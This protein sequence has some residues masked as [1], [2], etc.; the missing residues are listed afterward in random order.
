[1]G[2]DDGDGAGDDNPMTFT[3]NQV[4]VGTSA[5]SFLNYRIDN[6]EITTNVGTEPM[7]ATAD[8]FEDGDRD[9]DGVLEGDLNDSEDTGFV[10]YQ[11]KGTSSFETDIVDDSAGIGTGNAFS[12]F[13]ITSSGRAVSAAIEPISLATGE[14][15]TLEF[16]LRLRGAVVDSDRQ[17]RFGI[18]SDGGTPVN[19]DGFTQ[20]GDDLGYMVQLDTGASAASTAT[21]RGD[22]ANGLLSGGTR[23]TGG[24]TDEAAFAVDDNDAHRLGLRVE[25]AF[26]SDLGRDVNLLTFTFDGVVATEGVDSGDGMG[27]D[28]PVSYDFNQIS[29]G[30]TGVAFLD[31]VI[32][33]VEVTTE[34]VNPCPADI[35]PPFGILDLGDISAFVSGFQTQNPIADLAEPFGILDLNDISAFVAGFT[36]G[37]P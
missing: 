22:L 17:L 19:I 35:A 6:V 34:A 9:N 28:N 30:T 15:V 12:Q 29:V 7:F 24:T 2:T 32:D 37:C 20:T 16:D 5:V 13:S 31:I 14:S 23:A 3:F 27:D 18:H 26:D 36:A 1:M 33:N 10:W 21:I 4:S 8:G 25:R 11:S